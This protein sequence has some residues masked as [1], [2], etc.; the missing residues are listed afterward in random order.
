MV[1]PDKKR[2]LSCSG[3]ASLGSE[4]FRVEKATA[5]ALGAALQAVPA[6]PY[7]RG[8]APPL[9]FLQQPPELSEPPQLAFLHQIRSG[10]RHQRFLRQ[11]ARCMSETQREMLFGQMGINEF[12]SSCFLNTKRKLI[13]SEIYL[14][15]FNGG[16]NLV[17][18][19]N[20]FMQAA[21]NACTM[22]TT[23]FGRALH[24]IYRSIQRVTNLR[25]T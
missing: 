6:Q 3:K 20:R 1:S 10:W 8:P 4:V 22:S 9:S 13:R 5:T 25:L 23:S 16:K 24:R 12:L 15:I 14:K 7:P 2:G 11:S 18:I 21:E 19:L 17:I